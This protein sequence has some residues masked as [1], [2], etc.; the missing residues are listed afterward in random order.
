[1]KAIEA[2]YSKL[3][4]HQASKKEKYYINAENHNCLFLK[5]YFPILIAAMKMFNL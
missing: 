2:Q 3:Q 1:M 4:N 5:K